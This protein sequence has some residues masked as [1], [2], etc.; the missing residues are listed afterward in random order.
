MR[1]ALFPQFAPQFRS[2][3]PRKHAKTI[4]GSMVLDIRAPRSRQ[5]SQSSVLHTFS[6]S[7]TTNSPSFLQLGPSNHYLNTHLGTGRI[8]RGSGSIYAQPA[9]FQVSR[10]LPAPTHVLSS[11]FATLDTM[12]PFTSEQSDSNVGNE[13]SL[14]YVQRV[15]RRHWRSECVS[16]SGNS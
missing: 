2:E 14:L 1:E 7:Q 16:E 8:P 4:P 15:L 5:H 10:L 11:P 9:T 12:V 3:M 13:K 6:G